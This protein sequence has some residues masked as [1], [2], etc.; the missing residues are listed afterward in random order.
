MSEPEPSLIQ[1]R[2]A[3]QRKR[4]LAI[5][6]LI[7]FAVS[8]VWWLSSG[9]LDDS[10]DLD[11]MRLIVGVVNAGLAIAQ[12]FVLRG[13]LREVRMFE[14]RHGKDAGVQK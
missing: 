13:V 12:L 7:V 1:Q 8:A 11:V 10:A 3:L 6:L 5:A 4:T 2:L 14:E 9:L